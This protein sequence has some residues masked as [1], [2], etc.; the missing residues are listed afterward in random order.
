MP[1]AQQGGI[2]SLSAPA[3]AGGGL[4]DTPVTVLRGVSAKRKAQLAKLDIRTVFDL[5][6]HFPRDYEDW[7]DLHPLKDLR[8][9]EEMAFKARVARQPTLNRKGRLSMLRTVLRDDESAIKAIWFNQPY[10][11]DQ[12]VKDETYVFRGRVRV[13]GLD[14]TVQNPSFE[15]ISQDTDKAPPKIRAR[16]RL[17]AGLSQ[18]VLRGFIEQALKV[19][20]GHLPESLPDEVRRAHQLTAVDF[21]YSRI[22]N[23]ASLAE[24]ELCRRRLAFE[25]LF[26]IQAGLRLLRRRSALTATAPAISLPAAER[27][28]FRNVVNRLPF[29]LTTAQKKAINEVVAD[30]AR[31]QPMN[32]LVQGDVGSGKTVV[33]AMALLTA[34][35]AGYQGV[36]MA[37]TSILAAQHF[38]TLS[39]LLGQALN[40]AGLGI[41]LLTGSVSAAERRK[42]LAGL[43]DGSVAVLVGTHAVIEDKV[44]FRNLAL[45]VTDEQH[46]FGVRQRT[47]LATGATAAGRQP[48]SAH[49]LVMSATPIPRTLALILYGD[50]DL[51]I[52]NEKPVGR[53]PI[54]TYTATSRDRQRLDKMLRREVEAGNK[55]YIVCPQIEESEETDTAG[56][57]V[58]SAEAAYARLRQT[59]P[60]LKTGLLHGAL[61]AK[62]KQAVMDGFMGSDVDILVATTVIEVGVDQPEAT[63]MIIENAERFGLS[64]LH[65]LRGR[66]G[67]GDKPSI[68]VLVSDVG[69]GVARE[70][71]R[72][73][74]HSDDGFLLA[75]KDL[76][77]RGPGDFFGTRQHGLP[78]LHAANLYQDAA[79][80]KEVQTAIDNVLAEDPDLTSPPNRRIVTSLQSR[81]QEV[82]PNIGL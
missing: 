1:T 10:L 50:L 68:C 6:S 20:I 70:R 57:G 3:Q 66:I 59:L 12:L 34:A 46:R 38:V 29:E 55:C 31:S 15:K 75:E 44:Q 24:A 18:G 36:M 27:Q 62:E 80:L 28:T 72:T 25:E 64:Q 77:L 41:A 78:D 54:K 52:I 51:S 39:Q 63:L 19:L 30:L 45:A 67:R 40:Q 35:L 69:E 22:H 61:K 13:R 37:P 65:Q 58:L 14:V 2:Q 26:L 71:L 74:C 16:Y 32:R 21:A 79:L 47:L 82:F 76:E 42:I 56:N 33:A 11:A 23:P 5:I 7:T 8:E 60:D 9:G 49:V 48:P 17:T 53:Q 73:L 4:F 43:A 81:Y